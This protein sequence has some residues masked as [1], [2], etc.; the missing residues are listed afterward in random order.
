MDDETAEIELSP[1][2]TITTTTTT[3]FIS[4]FFKLRV[5]HRVPAR[6]HRCTP[7]PPRLALYAMPSTPR[8]AL[9]R[10]QVASC[11]LH[12]IPTSLRPLQQNLVK[13]RQISKKMTT[14]LDSFDTRLN[15]LEKSILPLYTAAQVLNKRRYNIDLTLAR[16]EDLSSTKQDLKA[17]ESLILRG[18]QPGQFNVYKD[19]MERLNTSI[20]F[21][22]AEDVA[23]TARLVETG[24]KKLT[25][26]Y[27]TL[28]AE[29][30]SGHTPA[31]NTTPL[32][33]TSFPASLLPTLT[34]IVAFLRTLPLPS[35]HPSH[36]ASKAIEATLR[37][38]QLGYAD[39]RGSWCA[40]CLEAPGKRLVAR[41]DTVD[42]LQTGRDFSDWAEVLLGTAEEE[43]KLLL[44]LALLPS[45]AAQVGR[46]YGALLAPL[47][48]LFGSVLGQLV[49]L[50]R[51]ELHR[52]NFLALAAYQGLLGLQ[53][54]WEEVLS[55]REGG[56]GE[57]NEIK[58][59]IASLRAICLRS[60]PEFLAD[61]KLA[62]VSRSA[63]G[64][65]G[66]ADTSVKVVE[67]V[68][69]VC[70]FPFV[71]IYAF[72]I[73]LKSFILLL[74][75]T[76]AYIERIPQVQSAVESALNALGDGNWRMGE[77]VQVGVGARNNFGAK[78]GEEDGDEGGILEH[79]VHDIISTTLNALKD[80][81]RT[82][83]RTPFDT[84]FLLNNTSYLRTHLLVS[85]AHTSVLTLLA[86]RTAALLTSSFR[87]AKAAYFDANFA[88]LLQTITEDAKER[89][90]GGGGGIG[91]ISIGGG[92]GGGGKAQAKERFT[93]FFDVLEEVVER[94]RFARVLE[95]EGEE[96][97][98]GE[99]G[100]EIC[101]LVGPSFAR[102]VQKMRDKEFSKNI[103]MTPEEVEAQLRGMFR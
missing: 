50:T 79:F 46:A 51:K 83:R 74:D 40:R 11:I 45:P 49:A 43:H 85:P 100:D 58:D 16:I 73:K 12:P 93:R 75:Q 91:G 96:R 19:A 47:L 34:P 53:R 61:I 20:V 37:E 28:A 13:T 82:S 71:W 64:T 90:K 66:A 99:V 25:L 18:P 80:L 44:E 95:E 54:G 23:Q 63:P 65:A 59:G 35:T 52:Y 102:F 41:A 26:L 62:G 84:T 92:G 33:L 60:F 7:L 30:S 68:H 55:R 3:A 29:G 31:P 98:R 15:K 76:V 101:L 32:T 39:M 17:D 81:A 56:G 8:R 24:T 77:G 67:F 1:I 38:T 88:P 21:N 22:S 48:R 89:E 78:K 9:P 97:E 86:P 6:H 10:L 69:T 2:T 27:T 103:K 42:A 14:I 94:H 36:P 57:K 4:R 87:T 5:Q 72:K 70:G